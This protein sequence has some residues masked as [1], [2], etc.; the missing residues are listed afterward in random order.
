MNQ[1]KEQPDAGKTGKKNYL[2]KMIAIAILVFGIIL[3]WGESAKDFRR[4]A[5]NGNAEAMYKLGYCYANGKGV[6]R[7]YRKAMHWYILAADNGIAAAQVELA[8]YY[9]NGDIDIKR[10]YKKAAYWYRRAANQGISSAQFKLGVCYLCGLGVMEDTNTA[11]Y[12]F[13]SAYRGPG[14]GVDRELIRRLID[15]ARNDRQSDAFNLVNNNS[16]NNR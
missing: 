4:A 3:A 11:I 8:D 5:E 7:N 9:Y 12:W 16:S 1:L 6:D 2:R 13:N 10:D 15:L 14:A